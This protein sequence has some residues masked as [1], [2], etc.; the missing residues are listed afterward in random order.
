VYAVVQYRITG[1]LLL[2]L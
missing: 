1:V 2:H